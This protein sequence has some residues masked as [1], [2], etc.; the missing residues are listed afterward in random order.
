MWTLL[1]NLKA[2]PHSLYRVTPRAPIIEGHAN[3]Y[4]YRKE[5]P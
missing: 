2:A 5:R 1:V 4:A 3:V